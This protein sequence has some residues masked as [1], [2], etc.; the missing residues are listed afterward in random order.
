MSSVAFDIVSKMR[1]D[2]ILTSSNS[3]VGKAPP[4]ITT[5]HTVAFDT[6]G[7]GSN[8]KYLRDDLGLRFITT[9]ETHRYDLGH[10]LAQSIKDYLLGKKPFS[11]NS[12]YYI[13]VVMISDITYLGEDEEN[14]PQFSINF[15]VTREYD[16]Y[17]ESNREEIL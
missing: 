4:S 12:V 1:D 9:G 17:P 16:S 13:R 14:R 8:P 11:Y 15:Q 6:P 7:G 3:F 5:T 10:D 2:G